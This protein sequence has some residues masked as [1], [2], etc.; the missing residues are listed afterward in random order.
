[1]AA[2][3][4]GSSYAPSLHFG[5]GFLFFQAGLPGFDTLFSNS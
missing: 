1:M 5:E 4:F 2:M 3:P